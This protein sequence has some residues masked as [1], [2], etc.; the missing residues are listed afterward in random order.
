MTS[1]S[2]GKGAV[3]GSGS[4]ADL[5]PLVGA[6]CWLASSVIA[7]GPTRGENTGWTGT[8]WNLGWLWYPAVGGGSGGPGAM[9]RWATCSH[10]RHGKRPGPPTVPSA[11]V[12]LAAGAE[13]VSMPSHS[14]RLPHG[15]HVPD[16]HVASCRHG[17]RLNSIDQ[18]PLTTQPCLAVWHVQPHAPSDKP[19]AR[20][21]SQAWPVFGVAMAYRS[22]PPETIR[23]RRR[24]FGVGCA[25]KSRGAGACKL[26]CRPR[27][28]CRLHS[29]LLVSLEASLRGT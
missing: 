12:G 26:F 24:R 6:A 18:L 8:G 27:L 23:L 15:S 21:V 10:V 13:P 20:S 14:E 9:P 19:K 5:S 28:R 29:P 3:S 16:R 4:M 7:S 25:G 22:V 11:L 17:T 1:G 2:G